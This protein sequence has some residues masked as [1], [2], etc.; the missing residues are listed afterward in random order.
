MLFPTFEYWFFLIVTSCRIFYYSPFGVFVC[1]HS[2]FPELSIQHLQSACSRSLEQ[3]KW[4]CKK[5]PYFT[6]VWL[7]VSEATWSAGNILI[8]HKSTCLHAPWHTYCMCTGSICM[9]WF[10]LCYLHRTSSSCR[11]DVL[12]HFF[13]F[14][15]RFIISCQRFPQ[16]Y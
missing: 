13:L 7:P 5:K 11:V 12:V 6:L 15:I 8:K 3:W 16:V 14:S 4:W 9:K 2:K 10:E 1:H